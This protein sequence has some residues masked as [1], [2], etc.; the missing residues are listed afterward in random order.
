M[1]KRKILYIPGFDPRS[2]SYYKKLLFQQFP[3]VKRGISF[4]EKSRFCFTQDALE[5]DYEILGWHKE[6]K[7]YW[8]AGFWGNIKGIKTIFSDYVFKGTWKRLFRLSKKDALQKPFSVYFF[9]VWMV[10]FVAGLLLLLNA[11]IGESSIYLSL[12]LT[13]LFL[14]VNF[15]LY[16]LIESINL[17]WVNRIMGFF[18]RY[19]QKKTPLVIHKEAVF[20][21][22]ILNA[23]KDQE[24]GKYDEVVLVAHSVGTILCLSIMADLAKEGRAEKLTVITLGHCVSGV[25]ILSEADWF[26]EK[27][28]QIKDRKFKWIDVTAGKDAVNFYKVTPAY[29]SDILPDLTLSAGYHQIFEKQFYEAVKWDF[30]KVHFLYLYKPQHVEMSRFNYSKL[31]FDPLLIKSLRL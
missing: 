13:T 8:P 5:I 29:H 30:Y 27:L 15:A 24:N 14:G 16:R 4:Q 6:V 9:A 12:I 10:A 18:V 21:E 25:S 20:K 22:I 1:I 26:N 7:A 3:E 17:F 19:S 31:L 28:R 11:V 2:E 23:L